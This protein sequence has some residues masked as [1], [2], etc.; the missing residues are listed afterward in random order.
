MPQR[1]KGARL[2]LRPASGDRSAVWIIK[3]GAA[4]RSTGC[5]K[6]DL[7]G[8]ERALAQYLAERHARDAAAAR[9]RD[10]NDTPIADVLIAY[11]Q[12]KH[13]SVA[14][15]D[16]LRG[17]IARLNDWLGAKAVTEV[18]DA[19]CAE[20]TAHRGAR[21]AAARELAYLRAAI[22]YAAHQRII[23]TVVPVRVPPSGKPRERWLT[24]PEMARLIKAAR[25]FPESRHLVLFIL[26]GR[27]TGTRSGAILNASW[28]PLPGRGWID[29]EAGVFHRSADGE[30]ASN[31][32]KTTVRLPSQLIA[33]LRRHRNRF[34]RDRHVISWKGE[35]VGS[36]KKSFARAVARAK[37]S[38][39]VTP[40]CLRHTAITWAMQAG[41]DRWEVSGYFGVTMKVIEEVYGHHHPDH[42]QS[43]HRAMSRRN[44][45]VSGSVKVAKV[46]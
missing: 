21:T 4:R 34:N 23:S 2:W 22:R 36:I 10:I 1:S 15:P 33:H 18:S 16:E 28:E 31:K 12:H 44:G 39:D 30:R 41:A 13:A 7:A 42:Q 19:L 17:Q 25:T 35:P 38:D 27:Y 20:Y 43:V 46:S 37:L 29:L 26:I 40:H 14:R 3:D 9:N 5:A 45:T 6:D 8:A 11:Y 24:R 32:R